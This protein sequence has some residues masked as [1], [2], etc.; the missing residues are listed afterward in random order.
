MNTPPPQ[1]RWSL[2]K[3]VK[4]APHTSALQISSLSQYT[5][6]ITTSALYVSNSRNLMFYYKCSCNL[7]AAEPATY[8]L[9]R[10]P[11]SL[12]FLQSPVFSLAPR[13]ILR[14]HFPLRRSPTQRRFFLDRRLSHTFCCLLTAST[15]RHCH[16]F[17]PAGPSPLKL[18]TLEQRCQSR[19]A[20]LR[21]RCSP[22]LPKSPSLTQLLGSTVV[23]PRVV[24]IQ[25]YLSRRKPP[26]RTVLQ[27][28][29]LDLAV[30]TKE[31][32]SSIT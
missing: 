32:I 17:P 4:S 29:N 25:S 6:P 23:T 27:Y 13:Q 15:Y 20:P 22:T 10:M 3:V 14:R 16:L 21:F 2:L 1:A 26:L 19:H 9:F 5:L 31:Y 12:L 11:L 28:G 18:H 8:S 7:P 24:H 30:A